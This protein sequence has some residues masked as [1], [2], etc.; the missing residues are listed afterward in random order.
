MLD[1]AIVLQIFVLLNPIYSIPVLI[2]AYKQK[3]DVSQVALNAVF[4]AFVIAVSLI[5]V[6]PIL[7]ETFGITLP[8]FRIAAG[9]V[10]F[11]LGID[12]IRP[13]EESKS[14]LGEVEALIS[15]IATPLLTG[16]ATISYLTVKSLEIGQIPLL[17]DVVVT[18]IFVGIVFFA[19]SKIINKINLKVVGIVSRVLGLFLTAVA[20]EMIAKG[21]DAIF[22]SRLVG[23]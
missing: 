6:G 7:F 2:N 3:M 18:F 19:F 9:V 22:F 13:K 16:P 10:L 11:L 4:V 1:F 21:V 23:A 17:V 20:I 12:M 8:S 15:I 14:D 5:F